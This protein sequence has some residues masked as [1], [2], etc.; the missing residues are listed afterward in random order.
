[1]FGSLSHWPLALPLFEL[2]LL[3]FD[4]V[5][6]AVVLLVVVRL[7]IALVELAEPEVVVPVVNTELVLSR[8]MGL[9]A[10]SLDTTRVL[11]AYTCIVASAP[12]RT[13]RNWLT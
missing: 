9:P 10:F 7:L 2:L 11:P 8:P 4:L 5:L 6:L 3:L 13:V 12:S 1:M